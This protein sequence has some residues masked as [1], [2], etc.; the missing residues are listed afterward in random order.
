[1]WLAQKRRSRTINAEKRHDS[2][3]KRDRRVLD[4]MNRMNTMI[5]FDLC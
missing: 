3:T 1:M 5:E 2:D 4:G